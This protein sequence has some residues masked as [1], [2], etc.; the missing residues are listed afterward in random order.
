MKFIKIAVLCITVIILLSTTY[1]VVIYIGFQKWPIPSIGPNP[2][3]LPQGYK[4]L[5][6]TNTRDSQN[7]P[8]SFLTYNN[9]QETFDIVS[10]ENGDTNCSNFKTKT[11][12]DLSITKLEPPT[13]VTS[14]DYCYIKLTTPKTT[15]YLFYWKEENVKYTIFTT[16]LKLKDDDLVNIVQGISNKK[17][18]LYLNDIKTLNSYFQGQTDQ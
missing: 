5:M 2:G 16:G 1:L 12:G 8:E 6:A 18:K 3:Y 14:T 13:I 7:H 11:T 4:L 9:N 17:W 15:K 10:E